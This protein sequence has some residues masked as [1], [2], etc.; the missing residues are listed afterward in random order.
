[1]TTHSEAG[2]KDGEFLLRM[3][4]DRVCVS[5]RSHGWQSIE[6]KDEDEAVFV[7]LNDHQMSTRDRRDSLFLV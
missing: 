3:A 1:V 6:A 7:D 5:V 2:D 4:Q